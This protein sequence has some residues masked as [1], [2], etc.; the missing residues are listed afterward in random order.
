MKLWAFALPMLLGEQV[1]MTS[2]LF[3]I[4][5]EEEEEEEEE[6]YKI[7]AMQQD[8]FD[9]CVILSKLLYLSEPHSSPIKWW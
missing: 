7:W 1:V 6:W 3:L 2:L 8:S 4:W 9:S 5:I